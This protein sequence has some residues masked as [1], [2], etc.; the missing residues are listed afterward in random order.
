MLDDI[1][2]VLKAADEGVLRLS[3]EYFHTIRAQTMPASLQVV[4]KNVLEN[5]RSALEYL[6]WAITDAFGVTSIRTSYPMTTG[7]F[8]LAGQMPR[9]MEGV[10]PSRPEIAEALGR[11]QPYNRPALGNLSKL[12]RKHKHQKLPPRELREAPASF[13]VLAT[14]GVAWY[15]N[16]LPIWLVRAGMATPPA[17]A[18]D[19]PSTEWH[20]KAPD[21]PVLGTLESI[22]TAV[23]EAT[24]DIFQA[25]GL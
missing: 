14:G 20:F 9:L 25:S 3:G 17:G 13:V 18:I 10:A 16:A 6:A 2:A 23:T 12:T 11:H 4:I 24:A 1:A 22:Q 8:D 19:A 7:P 21:V 15:G 5:Q